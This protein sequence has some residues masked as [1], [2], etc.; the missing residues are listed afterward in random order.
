MSRTSN[1][2]RWERATRR[3]TAAVRRGGA[4][5]GLALAL[6]ATGCSGGDEGPDQPKPPDAR[7]VLDR[8]KAT[9]D[10]AS[11]LRFA[12]TTPDPPA[13]AASLVSASGVAARPDKFQGDFK[14]SLGG[15]T[16]TVAVVSVGGTVYAKLPFAGGFQQ[17]DPAQFGVADP[18]RLL[19]PSSGV[20]NL[21]TKAQNPKLGS[22]SR[23]G[24]EVVQR[25]SATIPGE[26]IAQ[27]LVSADATAPVE[28]TFAVVDGTDQLR[29]AVV[30]GPFFRTGLTSTLTILLDRYG[31]PVEISAPTSG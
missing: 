27:I 7:A 20:S 11:S 26:A 2:R 10:A 28:A 15:A 9:L 19:D 21:L 17:V 23:V 16:A 8:A 14:V 1:A 6:L 13:G 25:V 31:E 12:V 22:K 30:K 5:L 4:V 18:G 24:S 29:E 3:R